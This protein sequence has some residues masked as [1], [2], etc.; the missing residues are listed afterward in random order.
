VISKDCNLCHDILA[1]GYPDQMNMAGVRD[2][3]EFIH[4]IDIGDAWKEF[5]CVECHDPLY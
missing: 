4:P 5:H 1:Q 3:L 2:S